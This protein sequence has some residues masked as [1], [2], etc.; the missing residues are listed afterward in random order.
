MRA[1][2]EAGSGQLKSDSDLSGP[3]VVA[4]GGGSTGPISEITGCN[5]SADF[6]LSRLNEKAEAPQIASTPASGG[7]PSQRRIRSRN[8]MRAMR[9]APERKMAQILK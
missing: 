6:D 3:P 9:R 4:A 1:S 8:V 2:T 5:F 7:F